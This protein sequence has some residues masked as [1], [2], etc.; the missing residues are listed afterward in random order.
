MATHHNDK[1]RDQK[2]S[3]PMATTIAPKKKRIKSAFQIAALVHRWQ[4]DELEIL[5]VTSRET[6]RWIL[7]KGWPISGKT[8]AAT[9]EQ[10]A[11]EE[12]GIVGHAGKKPLGRYASVKQIGE[13][14]LACEVEVY[15]LHFV[16]QKQKWKER[17]ERVCRWLPAE[18]AAAAI[19]EP[20]LASIIRS[21]AEDMQTAPAKASHFA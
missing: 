16:K 1:S 21:F 15:P 5:L 13:L 19:A 6:R 10:E 8:A 3:S 18:E 14:A 12:A 7:P 9:A 4:A 20:A 2:R 17:G 11:D